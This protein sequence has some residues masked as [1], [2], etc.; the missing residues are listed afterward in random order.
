MNFTVLC[1]LPLSENYTTLI[2]IILLSKKKDKVT[3][4]SLI[5]ILDPK[6]RSI[7]KKFHL[8][9]GKKLLRLGKYNVVP[10]YQKDSVKRRI[11]DDICRAAIKAH[12]VNEDCNN[13]LDAL[14]E[15]VENCFY[16]DR[17]LVS[18]SLL[19]QLDFHGVTLVRLYEMS[20][21]PKSSKGQENDMS[22]PLLNKILEHE[23]FKWESQTDAKTARE[24]NIRAKIDVEL[25]IL[26]CMQKKVILFDLKDAEQIEIQRMQQNDNI[27]CVGVTNVFEHLSVGKKQSF[28]TSMWMEMKDAKSHRSIGKKFPLLNLPLLTKKDPGGECQGQN[29]LGKFRTHEYMITDKIFESDEVS[30]GPQKFRFEMLQFFDHYRS[31]PTLEKYPTLA[32]AKFEQEFQQFENYIN[33]YWS[34]K[35]CT[36]FY[37]SIRTNSVESFF[38][39]RL[40][41]A[42]KNVLFGR[43]YL[44]RLLNCAMQWNQSHISECYKNFYGNAGI[45]FR[46]KWYRNVQ[47]RVFRKFPPY[48]YIER[49][50]GR[51]PTTPMCRNHV[52]AP[53]TQSKPNNV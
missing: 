50:K 31:A 8:V 7:D 52:Q 29:I 45:V 46:N 32:C 22:L 3:K 33:D 48:E 41:F 35:T 27:L 9:V 16:L 43:R 26:R 1:G 13:T 23:R 34:L 6:L 4:K 11:M 51:P 14:N 37:K 12:D 53:Q 20:L 49:R 19:K 44:A 30:T 10:N 21:S 25:Y 17:D 38:A 5:Y 39:T 40:F 42:P 47:A 36:Q 2:N 18:N 24:F 15:S 28:K